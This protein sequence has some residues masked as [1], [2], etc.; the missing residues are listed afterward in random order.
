MNSAAD[1]RTIDF[2]LHPD[3]LSRQ[4]GS[5]MYKAAEALKQLVA[6]ALDSDCARVEVRIKF[7]DLD[8]AEQVTIS[9]DGVGISPSDM[10]RAFREVGVHIGRSSKREPIGSR[11]IGRFGVFSLSAESRWQT[12]AEADGE[13]VQQTWSM[14]PGRRGI[15]VAEER[16]PDGATGTTIDM[17]LHQREDVARLFSSV[18]NVKRVIFNAFAAYLA[19]YEADVEIWVN[20][21]QVRVDEFVDEREVESIEAVGDVPSASLHHMVL[22]QHVDQPVPSMLVY[23]TKGTTVSQEVLPDEGIPGRKYLGLVDSPYLQDLTNTA[24]SDLAEFDAGF[25]ALKGEVSNRAKRYIGKRQGDHAK[26]FLERA[27]TKAYYPY[28]TP[29][30]TPVDRYR[31]QLYDGV[32]LSLEEEFKIDNAPANQQKLIFGMT[33]QLMQSEDLAS[34]LTGVLG[35]TGK[36]VAR[37][38][39]LLRRTSLSSVIAVADL[40]VDRLRFLD[41]LEVLLYGSPAKGVQERTQLHKIVEGHTWLFG[42]QYHLMGSDRRIATLLSEIQTLI[43]DDPEDVIEVDPALRDVPDLY[44]SRSKWHDGPKFH[45]HLIVEL[46]RPSLKVGARHVEQLWRYAEKIVDS[47][48]FGQKTNSHRFAFV[49]VSSDISDSVTKSYQADEEPGLLTRPSF[50][51]P[52]ELWALRWS[53]FL[54]RRREELKFL[55]NEVEITVDPELLD[56]LKNRVGEYLPASVRQQPATGA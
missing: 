25:R 3:L 23:A 21:E 56:Y 11:G 47:P 52:T 33:R 43:V 39:A 48:I 41:E 50:Q 55:E 9:D 27:R 5:A 16:V 40:L 8:T 19:R 37:F 18:R 2:S 26:A 29:P 32:L 15:D 31:R 53:D 17:T 24:K 49:V 54:D 20:D 51:H 44:L 13:F 35:L 38:A 14:V 6:N 28:K 7:N 22:G 1:K 4:L 30:A 12:V 34:V 10:E 42:E 36:E 46:K 45:Q